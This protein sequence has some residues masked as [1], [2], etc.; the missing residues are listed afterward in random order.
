MSG[1]NGVATTN[2][3]KRTI[4]EIVT[5]GARFG[6]WTVV[7][8]PTELH[9]KGFLKSRIQCQ[10]DCGKVNNILVYS[11]VYGYSK[12]C[13][14]CS[15]KGR[16]V[17]HG[18]AGAV[19]RYNRLYSIWRGM[20]KRCHDPLDT[21]YVR[22]GA[23]GVTICNEWKENY[24]AF[25][26]WA[27]ENG[28]RDDLTIDRW[29]DRKGNYEPRN[30]RWATPKQQQR[31]RDVT[32]F[33]T[34]GAE[35]KSLWDWADD[36]RCSVSATIIWSRLR[37]GWNEIHAVL[38]PLDSRTP[39][40]TAAMKHITAFGETKLLIDWP[41]DPRCTVCIST[42]NTRLQRGWE[43]AWAIEAPRGSTRNLPCSPPSPSQPSAAPSPAATR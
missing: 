6:R 28:Y 5:V 20:R 4:R 24:L 18:D 19:K 29:P 30:C 43:Q 27:L 38:A 8:L 11:V 23:K 26:D 42:I 40:K 41:N 33:I 12:S 36:P 39:E 14:P 21:S 1:F 13:K 22:Y 15:V 37:R 25:R 16:I 34:I 9:S 2:I 3:G 10:C 31:N 35:I 17:S 7:S 32:R